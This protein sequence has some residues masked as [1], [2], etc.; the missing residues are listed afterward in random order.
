MSSSNVDSTERD[1]V[2][3]S[4]ET[5]ESERK[6]ARSCSA[7]PWFS[8]KRSIRPGHGAALELAER[9]DPVAAQALGRLR[10]DAGDQ[11]HGLRGEA[12]DR[13]LA[14]EDDEA[15][16]LLGVGGDLGDQLVR[17]DPDR[18]VE[19][20]LVA[21]PADEVAHPGDGIGHLREVEVRLVE[22]ERLERHAELADQRHHLARRLAV[23]GEVGRQPVGVR[24]QPPRPRR[25]HRR[26]DAELPR[27]VRGGGDHRARP[28]AGHDHRLADQLRVPQKLDRHVERVHVEMGDRAGHDSIVRPPP[29]RTRQRPTWTPIRSGIPAMNAAIGSGS[30]PCLLGLLLRDQRLADDRAADVAERLGRDVERSAARRSR[31]A[32]AR[33]GGRGP[34]SRARG[35]PSATARRRCR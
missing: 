26:A 28:G 31:A 12:L 1:L 15:A 21:D 18:G 35:R 2:S 23:V 11:A 13:L 16:R 19:V 30:R 10:A 20:Q 22:R 25:R 8:P 7:R 33:R 17:A 9:L 29:A 24:A 3:R 6:C 34:A 5:G 27:L 32:S 14:G 4:V